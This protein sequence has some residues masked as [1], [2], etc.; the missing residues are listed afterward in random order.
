MP[1]SNKN[2][3]GKFYFIHNG[4][5][6]MAASYCIMSILSIMQ[7]LYTKLPVLN[8]H[9]LTVWF[10]INNNTIFKL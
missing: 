9:I 7:V 5:Y 6:I 8:V 4:S 1:Q 2:E 3:F 10:L